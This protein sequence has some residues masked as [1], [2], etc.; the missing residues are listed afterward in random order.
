[1]SNN[2]NVVVVGS[3]GYAKELGKQGTTSDF[4]FYNLK[5]G[6]STITFIEPTKYPDKL[7]PLFYAASMADV[8]IVV[9]EVLDYTVGECIL[10]LD[11][12]GVDRGYIVLKNYISKDEVAPLFKDTV[13][14]NY[15]FVEDNTAMLRER[16]FEY[17]THTH[18]ET[19]GP[20]KTEPLHDYDHS[21]TGT[22]SIDHYFN[23]RGIGTVVLGTV[24]SGVVRKHE[25][26][27]VLPGSK[28]AQI[29]SIQKHDDDFEWASEGD[30]VGI[31][32]K[33]ITVDELDR[34]FVLTTDESIKCEKI[35]TAQAH[36]VKYWNHALE[37]GMV[38]Y[39]GHWMQFVPARVVEIFVEDGDPKAPKLTIA[40]EKELVYPPG[41][42]AVLHHLEGK[43]LRVIGTMYLE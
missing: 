20:E 31:A 13:A 35:L 9:I 10:M 23:V 7:A 2:L 12:A 19:T 30:R 37:E 5:R 26:V 28:T 16:L 21:K 8:A 42:R 22:V 41:A 34:G 27:K 17:M 40:L 24:R 36:L 6:E 11:C 1:M 33:N 18:V 29:R 38:L 25:V 32:L 43:K 15:E 39:I 3:A 14:Q 4:T